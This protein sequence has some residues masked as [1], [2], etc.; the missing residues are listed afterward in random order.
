MVKL[1]RDDVVV[2]RKAVLRGTGRI[3]RLNLAWILDVNDEKYATWLEEEN[4]DPGYIFDGF[5]VMVGRRTLV[6]ET[7]E[8]ERFL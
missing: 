7:S 2:G 6:V 1:L 4:E 3:V 5:K 8:F